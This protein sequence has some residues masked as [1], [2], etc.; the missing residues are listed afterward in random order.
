MSGTLA[1]GEPQNDPFL[2]DDD[3]GDVISHS[4]SASERQD[5]DGEDC[6]FIR[7]WSC[8]PAIEYQLHSEPVRNLE[9]TPAH[10]AYLP[11]VCCMPSVALGLCRP[12]GTI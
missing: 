12:L 9:H 6:V 1:M 3:D 8:P 10:K 2:D 11:Q 5:G 7:V 4:P